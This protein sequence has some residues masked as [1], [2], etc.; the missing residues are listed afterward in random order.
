MREKVLSEEDKEEGDDCDESYLM[1]CSFRA[2][3]VLEND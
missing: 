2:I 3:V 1:N